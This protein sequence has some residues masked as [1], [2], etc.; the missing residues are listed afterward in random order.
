MNYQLYFY[1]H[2]GGDPSL[3]KRAEQTSLYRWS[4]ALAAAMSWLVMERMPLK[5]MVV[6]V[7]R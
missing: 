5:R 2:W 1:L 3:K 6:R 4:R 7:V